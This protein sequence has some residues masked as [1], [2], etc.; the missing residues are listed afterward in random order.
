MIVRRVLLFMSA[1]ILS[2][3]LAQGARIPGEVPFK[4]AQGFGIVVRGG[5]GPL[6]N[7]NFLVDTGAVPSVLS[8][9]VASRIGVTGVPGSLALLHKDIEALYVTVDDVH[10]G[11][12]CAVGLPMVVVDLAR[13]E[14]LL[15]TRIDA[16]IGLD[17]LARQSF[18]IDFK[19][20]KITPGLSG[21]ARHVVPVEICNAAGAPYWVVPITLAGHSF[22]VLLDT[23]ANDLA[24]FAGQTPKSVL[25]LR[26]GGSVAARTTG[27][28]TRP[29]QPLLLIL[30]DMSLKKQLAVVLDAP[31]GALQQID[32]VL[33]PT[34][35]GITRIEFDLEHKCLRWDA[36]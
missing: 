31:P 19:H 2:A 28:A 21:L 14:R 4:L 27:E 18:S 9:R 30:G 3:A 35:L 6:N 17:M 13:F 26:G 33:G 16:I 32:G 25:D 5:I 15:G 8:E 12:I 10:F 22:R 7:L 29:L 23:G 20:G 1:A 34:A 36:E 11:S 24:L